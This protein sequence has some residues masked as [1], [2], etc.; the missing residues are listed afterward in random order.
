MNIGILGSGFGLYGYLPAACE[1]LWTPLILKKSHAAV[2]SRAELQNYQSKIKYVETEEELI[3]ISNRLII[4]R[5][6]ERQTEILISKKAFP[7]I[8]HL[9]L[10]KPLVDKLEKRQEIIELLS[11]KSFS[12]AYLWLYTEWFL[13]F[14]RILEQV[15]NTSFI[16][17]WEIPFI[18]SNW[19]SFRE[20]GGGL[21]QNYGVHFLAMLHKLDFEKNCINIIENSFATINAVDRNK[22]TICMYLKYSEGRSFSLEQ[23]INKKSLMIFSAETPFGRSHV[24][25][26]TDIRVPLLSNYLKTPINDLNSSSKE[27]ELFITHLLDYKP[28]DHH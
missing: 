26:Q 27:I 3:R 1:N 17:N 4:A 18:D 10:E 9:Y 12:I 22:N 11:T 15:N 23:T 20:K 5:N 28:L 21:I 2:E 8:E 14:K 13:D 6:P 16:I 24:K 25:G 19:K 7:E